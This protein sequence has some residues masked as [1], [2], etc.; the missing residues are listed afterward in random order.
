[1]SNFLGRH[2][3]RLQLMFSRGEIVIE[4]DKVFAAQFFGKDFNAFTP[5][6]IGS[7]EAIFFALIFHLRVPLR[8]LLDFF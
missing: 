1:M 6:E 7:A 8:D 5:I 3:T 4:T 2:F